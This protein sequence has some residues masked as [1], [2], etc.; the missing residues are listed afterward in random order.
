MQEFLKNINLYDSGGISPEWSE[1]R[2]KFREKS[3]EFRGSQ[4]SVAALYKKPV[5]RAGKVDKKN[6]AGFWRNS[7]EFPKS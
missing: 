1:F 6:L 4:W 3:P 7:V 5:K 2:W